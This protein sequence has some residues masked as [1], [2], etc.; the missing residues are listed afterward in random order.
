ML[1]GQ[2]ASV[3]RENDAASPVPRGSALES[4]APEVCLAYRHAMW[5]LLLNKRSRGTSH[6]MSVLERHAE[7]DG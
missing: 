3:T 2:E 6:A 7:L 4:L 1:N 5:V